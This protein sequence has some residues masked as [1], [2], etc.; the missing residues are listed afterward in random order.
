MVIITGVEENE[1]ELKVLEVLRAK[2]YE[3]RA[4]S[5]LRKLVAII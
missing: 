4:S 5:Q 2:G 1:L 3:L